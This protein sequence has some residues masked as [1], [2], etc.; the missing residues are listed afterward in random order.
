MKKIIYLLGVI[1]LAII[2]ILNVLFTAHLDAKEH[3]TIEW[4]N[5]I[6]MIGLALLGGFLFW[7]TKDWTSILEKRVKEARKRKK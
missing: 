6:Y 2:I 4:H 3:I 1:F 5:I 7:S